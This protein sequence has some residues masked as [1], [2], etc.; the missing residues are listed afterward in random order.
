MLTAVHK[1]VAGKK[2]L[3]FGKNDKNI[4]LQ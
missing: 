2:S 3:G 1:M 4:V